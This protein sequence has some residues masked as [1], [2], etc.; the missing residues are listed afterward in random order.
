MTCCC[1][2]LQLMNGFLTFWAILATRHFCGNAGK[3]KIHS[4]LAAQCCP[5]QMVP[6]GTWSTDPP[7]KCFSQKSLQNWNH[8]NSP[9]KYV[10]Y[11]HLPEAL[12]LSFDIIKEKKK[13]LLILVN[14]ATGQ[15][16][17]MIQIICNYEFVLSHQPL[18]NRPAQRPL[19]RP[20]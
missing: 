1:L 13:I 20:Q 8:S 6:S 19:K 16:M 14:G 18:C 7:R 3:Q 12:K 4:G 15:H 2:R 10:R 17:E 11:R 9:W 5:G